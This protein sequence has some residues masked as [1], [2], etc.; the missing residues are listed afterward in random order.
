MYRHSKTISY[1]IFG[2]IAIGI[3]TRIQS[4]W[5]PLLIFGIVFYLYKF[6][7]KQFQRGQRNSSRRSSGSPKTNTKKSMFRVIKG[8]K[9]DDDDTPKYH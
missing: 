1:I 8:N 5:I 7:P 2:L 4:F 3:L 9:K 6:P